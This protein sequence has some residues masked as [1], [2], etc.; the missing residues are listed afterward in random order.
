MSRA[1][2]FLVCA[3][4]ALILPGLH[5]AEPTAISLGAGSY[6]SFPPA[7]EG[8]TP[9]AMLDRPIYTETTHRPI[10][11]NDWWTDLLVSR[12]AGTMWALPFG[13]A[14]NSGGL[15]LYYSTNWNNNGRTLVQ[16][17]P[18]RVE[19]VVPV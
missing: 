3:F 14:A 9:T 13:V 8:A 17:F 19:G 7:H 5:A 16:E 2:C 10:P 18:L 4:S 12:Y 1:P 6:A 15:A 11:S